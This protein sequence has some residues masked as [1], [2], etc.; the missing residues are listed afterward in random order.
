MAIFQWHNFLLG[1]IV[2][3]IYFVFIH[4]YYLVVRCAYIV[5]Y[6]YKF[7]KNVRCQLPLSANNGLSRAV[8]CSYI[9]FN[10]KIIRIIIILVFRAQQISTQTLPGTGSH[11]L[12]SLARATFCRCAV[13]QAISTSKMNKQFDFFSFRT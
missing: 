11:P 6:A 1:D 13:S 12:L 2:M 5:I 4:C 10:P 9:L 3:C 8:L 7:V